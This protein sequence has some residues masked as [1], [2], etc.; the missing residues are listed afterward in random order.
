M[1]MEANRI[2]FFGEL[3]VVLLVFAT[4]YA[5]AGKDGKLKWKIL[6]WQISMFYKGFTFFWRELLIWE[7]NEI[8][9]LPKFSFN[10]GIFRMKY[11]R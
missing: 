7:I 3:C 10:F 6:I 9:H 2:L 1:V 8:P 11:S 4:D 5:G